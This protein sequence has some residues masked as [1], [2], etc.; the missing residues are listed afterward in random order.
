MTTKPKKRGRGR[1]P[2]TVGLE[3]TMVCVRLSRPLLD[4]I[5]QEVK[6]MERE[7]YDATRSQAVVRLLVKGTET[8]DRERAAHE[9]V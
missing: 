2:V 1:P 6:L 5:D 8:L 4:R 3:K 7:G 9:G